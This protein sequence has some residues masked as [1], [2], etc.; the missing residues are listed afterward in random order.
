MIDTLQSSVISVSRSFSFI[1]LD[2]V[3][4]SPASRFITPLLKAEISADGPAIGH[5]P[6]IEFIAEGAPII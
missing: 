1:L 6:R 3:A 5:H 2:G 4:A